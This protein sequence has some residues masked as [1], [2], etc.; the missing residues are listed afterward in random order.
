VK[1]Y[2]VLSALAGV[3]AL[4][5]AIGAQ[6]QSLDS[7]LRTQGLSVLVEIDGSVP[8]FTKEQLSEYLCKQMEASHLT[9]WHFVPTTLAPMGGDQPSNRIVW[10]FKPLPYGG[11]GTR[12]IGPAMSKARELFGVGRAISID[13]K[14][15]L[16]DEFEATTF[17]QVTVK[18]GQDDPGLAASVQKIMKSVVTNAF[19][20]A[21]PD[22]G[23][24]LRAVAART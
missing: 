24:P 9:G 2:T 16:N 11:G 8:G 21:S 13:A 20:T 18:G 3:I 14:V 12:Y 22:G 10:Y 19:L 6:A 4:A 7:G 17:D 1:R 15:F 23:S 5:G